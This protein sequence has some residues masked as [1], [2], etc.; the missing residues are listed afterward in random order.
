MSKKLRNVFLVVLL[1]IAGL[2]FWALSWSGKTTTVSAENVDG[3]IYN[4]A[5]P[6]DVGTQ[7]IAIRQVPALSATVWY[8][9]EVENEKNKTMTYPY[10]IKMGDPIGWVAIARYG[11]QAMTAAPFDLSAAPY[12]L[13]VLSPGFSI[14]SNAYAWLAEHLASYGFV[15]VSP[16]HVEQLDPQ[17]QLWRAAITRPGDILAV[18]DFLD[19]QVQPGGSFERLVDTQTVAVIGHSYGGYTAQAA[20][21]AQIDTASLEAHCQTVRQMEDP[22]A[23][24]CDMLL[25]HL[26]DMAELAGMDSVPAG[27]WP[28]SAD[29]RVDAIVSMAGDAFLFGQTGLTQIT[30]PVMA[31]GGTIDEDSPFKW[32]TKATYE[33][34]ASDEK[35]EIAL[36]GADHMIFT[37]ECQSVRRLAKPLAGEFCADTEWQ[38]GDAHAL[39]NHFITAFLLAELQDNP[40]ARTVLFSQEVDFS[41]ITYKSQ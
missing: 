2:A 8:P 35:I 10:Q 18:F 28:S 36:E 15:V 32:N 19:A 23:W 3:A 33:D 22:S 6:F 14:A 16:D 31:V 29:P 24:L 17:N 40:A 39:I 38:R 7:Q 41:G 37:G 20:A 11:G 4:E 9:A 12:P 34:I 25:P 13:V 27:L 5:G 26:A 30:V 1:I 21:G